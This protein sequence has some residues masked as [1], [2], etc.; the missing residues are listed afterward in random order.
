MIEEKI[1]RLGKYLPGMDTAEVHFDEERNP[2]ISDKEVCEVTLE[3]HGHHVRA[4]ANGVDH[5]TAVDKAVDKL[6]NKMHKLKTKLSRKPRHKDGGKR[7]K[8]KK[9]GT[10]LPGDLVGAIE[11]PPPEY[12]AVPEVYDDHGIEI[13]RMKKVEKLALTAHDAASR[14]ELVDHSFYFFT[15]IETGRA[16]VVYRRSDGGVGLIDE[17]D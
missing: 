5:L 1:D 4:K 9:N 3:G 6:E 14:M 10:A 16:A 15:N 8:W 2:R 11:E 17:T 7:G 12:S 13:S